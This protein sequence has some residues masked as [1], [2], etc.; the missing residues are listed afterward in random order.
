MKSFETFGYATTFRGWSVL[1]D[2]ALRRLVV[3]FITIIHDTNKQRSFKL[4]ISINFLNLKI[5]S[6]KLTDCADA[7]GYLLF[8]PKWRFS[9]LQNK[10]AFQIVC[11]YQRP[12]IK[13]HNSA[14]FLAAHQISK[15]SHCYLPRPRFAF[16]LF[17]W[18]Y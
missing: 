7:V 5:V 17:F 12:L 3:S 9:V 13:Q 10:M 1:I 18:Q 15:D 6:K 16:V 11:N 4:N 8:T 14:L 2:S